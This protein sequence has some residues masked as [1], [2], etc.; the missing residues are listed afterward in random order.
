MLENVA[1]EF[2][3]NFV[4]IIHVELAHERGKVAVAEVGRQYLL[5]ENLHLQN[6]KAGAL[7]IPSDDVIVLSTLS[8]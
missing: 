3:A 7:G 2:V 4:E 1:V 6:G 8:Q 5:F